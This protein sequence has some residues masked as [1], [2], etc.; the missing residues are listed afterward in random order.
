MANTMYDVI[1]IGSGPAGL[2]AGIYTIR[3][4]LSTL[5]LAGTRWGGQL[6]LTTLVENYPGFSDG[7][8][9]PDLMMAMRKQAERLGVDVRNIDFEKGDFS[10]RPFQV[11]A[12]GNV[13]ES[14]AIILATGA[15]SKWLN[16]K[17]E[18][19]LRGKGVSTCATCDA[20]FF[21]GKRVVVVGGGDSAMEE[22]LVLA[23]VA[24]SVTIIHRRDAFRA[25][26]AMQDRVQ[27]NK[28]ISTL[29]NSAVTEIVGTEKVEAVMV[30]NLKDG[31]EQKLPIDG[32]FVAIGH[33]PNTQ[34]L[35]GV[36]LDAKGYIVRKELRDGIL[37]KYQSAT[38]IPGVF[39]SGDV[40][41]VLYRQAITAAGFGC[42]AALDAYRWIQEQ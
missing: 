16:V 2:T 23:D 5:L 4:G 41:D 29:W 40:H 21:R 11:T 18:I 3:S 39:V 13:F 22:A 6:M 38:N 28:K 10:K 34:S 33:Q 1:I 30:K 14:K 42:M 24:T 35:A 36:E 12:G 31:K 15:E 32:V 37:P 8:Q 17:G 26:K 27:A 20:F 25:S 19:Q 9:G 7:I